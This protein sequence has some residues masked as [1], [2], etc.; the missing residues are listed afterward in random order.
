MFVKNIS[1]TIY[2]G[3]G[4]IL[5]RTLPQNKKLCKQNVN[6]QGKKP[7]GKPLWKNL[8]NMWKSSRFPQRSQKIP[9][10]G[11][12]KLVHNFLHT[13]IVWG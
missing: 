9:H 10:T 2:C 7:W 4:K 3:C 12:E 8:W 1:N 13:P 11:K 5:T 6:K